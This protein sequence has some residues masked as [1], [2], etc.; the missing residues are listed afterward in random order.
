[1][2]GRH[3]TV[4]TTRDALQESRRR[5]GRAYRY[6]AGGIVAILVFAA[7]GWFISDRVLCMSGTPSLT[8]AAAPDIAPAI[9]DAASRFHEGEGRCVDITVSTREP[10][11]MATRLSGPSTSAGERAQVWLPDSS[12]WIGIASN[13]RRGKKL[14]SDSPSSVARSP[15]V[16]AVGRQAARQ[17]GWPESELGW[18]SLLPDSGD[19]AGSTFAPLLTD[20]MRDTSGLAALLAFR[21]LA[22]DAESPDAKLAGIVRSL[23]ENIAPTAS[24]QFTSLS[25][26]GT[27]S[28]TAAVVSEQA[29]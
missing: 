11:D 4:S 20:P 10:A 2:S 16:L 27:E 29:V 7:G 25:Q 8:V 21:K 12:L 22:A 28:P 9:T 1:M 18:K 26:A 19:G 3:R 13:S 6:L 23:G 17:A 24:A 15:V 5:N 14:L